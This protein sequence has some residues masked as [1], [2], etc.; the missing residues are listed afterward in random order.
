MPP[1]ARDRIHLFLKL[2]RGSLATLDSSRPDLY[3]H[4]L[5]ERLGLR[6][7]QLFAAQPDVVTRL[8]TL[9]RFGELL[10][11]SWMMKRELDEA[12]SN[13]AIDDMYATGIAAGALG[14]KVLGAGG[15]GF[16]LLFAPPE[17]HRDILEAIDGRIHV[18]FEFE[19]A[20]SQI[21]FY[22]PGVDYRE[23]EKARDRS[24]FLRDRSIRV[25]RRR[26]PRSFRSSA[27]SPR[28]FSSARSLRSSQGRRTPS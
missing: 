6:R 5:I 2:Y 4:R 11:R 1:E 26:G 21:I 17:K 18:P 22:E 20:G 23:A 9:A 16:L 10:H 15:G 25:R 28:S 7:Q 3:V 19:P 14:G 8:R 13:S 27:V 12:I 24:A